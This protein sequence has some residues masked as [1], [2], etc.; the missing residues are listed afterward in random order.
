MKPIQNLTFN[1]FDLCVLVLLVVGIFVG[2][3]R[4]MSMELLSLLQWLVIVFGGAMACGLLGKSLADLSGINPVVTYITAYLLAAIVVKILFVMIKRM[5]GEKL[6]S[7]ELFGKLEYY[8]GMLAGSVRFACMIL[9]VLAL[10]NAK[11]VTKAELQ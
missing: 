4:G 6:V 2:R 1:W 9:F 10:L 5:A 7:G 8:L 11:Q 3:K